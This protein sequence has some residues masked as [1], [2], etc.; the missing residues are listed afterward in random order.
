M[1]NRD[2]E[3]CLNTETDDLRSTY[4][5]KLRISV[6]LSSVGDCTFYW[7]QECYQEHVIQNH[8]KTKTTCVEPKT[9]TRSLR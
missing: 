5:C 3:L 7:E 6:I 1:G 9:R 2:Q 4:G 8:D